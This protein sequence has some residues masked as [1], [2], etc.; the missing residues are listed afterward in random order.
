MPIVQTCKYCFKVL[1]MT[2]DEIT[3]INRG[4]VKTE[5]EYVYAHV[6]CYQQRMNEVKNAPIQSSYARRSVS[7]EF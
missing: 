4:A 7:D 2:T 6:A 1:D 5:V 3:P